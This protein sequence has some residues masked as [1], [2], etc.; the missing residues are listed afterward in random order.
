MIVELS[1]SPENLSQGLLF[2]AQYSWPFGSDLKKIRLANAFCPLPL[3]DYFNYVEIE[4][5]PDEL[6]Q[7]ALHTWTRAMLLPRHLYSVV[8]PV[9][10]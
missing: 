9:D 6:F 8:Y 10:N 5:N 2:Y 3:S 7:A 4:I 1:C